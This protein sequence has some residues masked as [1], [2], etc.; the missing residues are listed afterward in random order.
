VYDVYMI[1]V[2]A[3]V[4]LDGF[5]ADRHD[6]P[7]P[8]FDWYQ[9][10]DVAIAPGDP[11]RFFH[12]TEPTAEYLSRTWPTIGA[13]V[14]GRRL[15]DIIN[16]WEGRPTAGD[17][18][19]VVTHEPPTDWPFPDAPFTFATDG[20][21]SAIA[22]AA[23]FAGDRDVYVTAGDI[24]GQ[25]LAAGLV[26]EV[27]MELAPVILGSGVR[28]FGDYSGEPILL[29]NPEVVQ[30]DRVTHLRYRLTS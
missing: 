22:R 7:G 19:F 20:V 17:A 8:I 4:S 24:A 5:I 25:A 29:E 9:N 28:Y 13:V 14:I 12:V 30:G 1:I 15:F 26:D 16:G 2:S 10:G 23:A 11:Q 18:V 27:R 21:E 6:D 3:A